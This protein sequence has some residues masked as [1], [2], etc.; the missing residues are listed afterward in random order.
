MRV[1]KRSRY[2]GCEG[3]AIVSATTTRRTSFAA[4][5]AM[6]M[7]SGPMVVN[8][9]VGERLVKTWRQEMRRK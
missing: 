5:T 8:L 2:G 7:V 3:K 9:P 4:V 1:S 6:T